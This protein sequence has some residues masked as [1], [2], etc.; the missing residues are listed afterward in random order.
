MGAVSTRHRATDLVRGELLL[1]ELSLVAP[2]LC[3][4]TSSVLSGLSILPVLGLLFVLFK[5]KLLNE[6]FDS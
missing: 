4:T 3:L 6:L 5:L 1:S 2:L